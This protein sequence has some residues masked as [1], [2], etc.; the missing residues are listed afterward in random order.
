MKKIKLNWYLDEEYDKRLGGSYEIPVEDL[1][2]IFPLLLKNIKE[3][4]NLLSE[5]KKK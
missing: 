1:E 5:A 2:K 4:L 3:T